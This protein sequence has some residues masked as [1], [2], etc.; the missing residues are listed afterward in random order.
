MVM[1]NTDTATAVTKE[2][3]STPKT[4]ASVF[5]GN[6]YDMGLLQKQ[7]ILEKSAEK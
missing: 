1:P 7:G 6:P 3:K 4:T 5:K 2:H